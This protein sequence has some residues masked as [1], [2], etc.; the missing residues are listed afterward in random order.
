[1]CNQYAPENQSISSAEQI[2]TIENMPAS[3]KQ[4]LQILCR[5]NG[6]SVWMPASA[7][8]PDHT[9]KNTG[10]PQGGLPFNLPPYLENAYVSLTPPG[11]SRTQP[12]EPT[13]RPK[14]SYAAA[15]RGFPGPNIVSSRPVEDVFVSPDSR[16]GPYRRAPAVS[17]PRQSGM[18][19]LS[20]GHQAESLGRTPRRQF[21]T[22]EN[23]RSG[24]YPSSGGH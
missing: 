20:Q 16:S 15:A 19:G 8:D 18:L 22:S 7:L 13:N 17:P 12:S 23:W 2:A 4:A 21:E 11:Y 14:M 9:C 3:K 1:M 10:A 6:R 5:C 24:Q